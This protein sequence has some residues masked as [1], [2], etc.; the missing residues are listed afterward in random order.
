MSGCCQGNPA[1]VTCWWGLCGCGGRCVDAAGRRGGDEGEEGIRGAT[2][3][4][5][6]GHVSA[7]APVWLF[8]SVPGVAF[9]V[10]LHHTFRPSD[11]PSA[12]LISFDYCPY[13]RQLLPESWEAHSP[14]L[15]GGLLLT[16]SSPPWDVLHIII[17]VPNILS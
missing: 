1:S 17:P 9:V 15:Y 3:G 16:R 8:R 7:G 13:W 10:S 12:F 4:P 14:E 11:M 2:R 6:P 5:C